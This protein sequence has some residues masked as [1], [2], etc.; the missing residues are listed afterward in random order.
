MGISVHPLGTDRVKA[1]GR[2]RAATKYKLVTPYLDGVL[3]Y[4]DAGEWV[5]ALYEK[6]GE[7]IEYRLAA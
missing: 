6:E 5:K 4:D 7:K 1:G 3:W 2:E